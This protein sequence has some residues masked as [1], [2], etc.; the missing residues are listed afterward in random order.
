[1]KSPK[2]LKYVTFLVLSACLSASAGCASGGEKKSENESKAA[3]EATRARADK[4]FEAAE[5]IEDGASWLPPDAMLIGAVG[6]EDMW[7]FVGNFFPSGNSASDST[8]QSDGSPEDGTV[9]G[10]KSEWGT[11]FLDRVGFDPMGI[12]G[13]AFGASRQ[14]Q[15][16]VLFGDLELDEDRTKAHEIDGQQAYA[17][18]IGDH[19]ELSRVAGDEV[20]LVPFDQPRAGMALFLDRSQLEGPALKSRSSDRSSDTLTESKMLADLPAGN[21]VI[22]GFLDRATKQMMAGAPVEPPEHVGISVGD[23]L[24]VMIDGS[25]ESLDDIDGHVQRYRKKA[26]VEVDRMHS[27]VD[28]MNLARAAGIVG[29]YHLSLAYYKRFETQRGDG[30]LTYRMGL[31]G[32]QNA[33]ALTGIAAAVAVPAFIKYIRRSKTSESRAMTRKLADRAR[34]YFESDQMGC[35]AIPECGQPWH[36]QIRPGMPVPFQ[37]KTF[38]GGTNVRLVTTENP[39]SGGK[40]A[41]PKPTVVQSESDAAAQEIL[42]SLGVEFSDPTYFQYVYE[43][44][45]GRGVDAT[46]TIRAIADFEGSGSRNHTLRIELS[47]DPE[48][49]RVRVSPPIILNEFR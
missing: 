46:A 31:P 11:L 40:K 45:P 23:N 32:G 25:K 3:T 21:A 6:A 17:L 27:Q 28:S 5:L 7:S 38:P 42:E 37:D 48:T 18:Q 9:A 16:V 24:T 36:D 26:K 12:E 47:V 20:W 29:Y 2:S 34:A 19:R 14:N 22:V 15:T 10:M 43:T 41:P 13:M 8:Q 4:P 33:M 39:P 35:G 1:M 44:G 30:R 49:Q